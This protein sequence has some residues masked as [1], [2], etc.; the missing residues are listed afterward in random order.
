V[1]QTSVTVGAAGESRAVFRSA[2]WAE[3]DANGTPDSI[4]TVSAFHEALGGAEALGCQRPLSVFCRILSI[5]GDH[6]EEA[7]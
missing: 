2:H 7:P 6:E 5:V 1:Y 3:H 4:I